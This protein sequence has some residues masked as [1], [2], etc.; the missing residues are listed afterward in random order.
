MNASRD[1]APRSELHQIVIVG[2]GAGGLELA[3]GL[4][5]K[6]GKLAKAAVTLIEK[7][8]TH[9]WKPHLH[10]TTAGTMDLG[11]YET[12]YIP[13]SG[14]R[15][16]RPGP[17]AQGNACSSSLPSPRALERLL[18]IASIFAIP[19]QCRIRGFLG[20]TYQRPTRQPRPI[21]HY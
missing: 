16:E 5:D 6:F 1:L 18:A 7:A 10:E 14:R 21:T 2:G 9:F 11:T 4:G 20:V 3:T 17:R 12:T 8:R 19:G 15:D 13:L